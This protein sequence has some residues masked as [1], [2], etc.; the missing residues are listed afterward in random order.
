MP[1]LYVTLN[2]VSVKDY[3]QIFPQ[4]KVKVSFYME[5]EG[6]PRSIALAYR[7]PPAAANP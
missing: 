7:D 6:N 5:G 1:K 4:D 3:F 2:I